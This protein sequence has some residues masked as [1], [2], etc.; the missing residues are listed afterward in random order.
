METLA[1]L[2]DGISQSDISRRVGFSRQEL[3]KWID[4][5]PVS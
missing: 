5:P 4:H 1:F 3:N 2:A